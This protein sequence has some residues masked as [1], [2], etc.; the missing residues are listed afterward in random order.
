ME[1]KTNKL[2]RHKTMIVLVEN[3]YIQARHSGENCNPGTQE[4]ETGGL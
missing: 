3:Q 4:V 1:V 2:F